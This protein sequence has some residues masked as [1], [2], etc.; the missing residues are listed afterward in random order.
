MSIDLEAVKGRL[1]RATEGPWYWEFIHPGYLLMQGTPAEAEWVVLDAQV[2]KGGNDASIVFA[3]N[4]GDKDFI[5]HARTDIP[6]L[7]ME[8]ERLQ[9][10][11]NKGENND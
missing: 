6:N 2:E 3:G 4:K 1:D 10:A 7:I 11:L 9:H 8:I 5:A